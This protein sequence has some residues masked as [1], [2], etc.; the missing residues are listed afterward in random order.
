MKK[1]FMQVIEDED[2]VIDDNGE[3]VDCTDEEG[4]E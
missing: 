3:I 2:W 4:E 1:K